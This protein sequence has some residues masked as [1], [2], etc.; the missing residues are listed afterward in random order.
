MHWSGEKNSSG[1][2][3]PGSPVSTGAPPALMGR[4]EADQT[5]AHAHG[6]YGLYG[7][8]GTGSTGFTG[9]I[10]VRALRALRA[11]WALLGASDRHLFGGAVAYL[12]SPIWRVCRLFGGMH[13]LFGRGCR[14]FGAVLARFA[15][16]LAELP[17]IWRLRKVCSCAGRTIICRRL[18][19]GKLQ[20]HAKSTENI[21]KTMVSNCFSDAWLGPLN[22]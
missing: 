11:L 7:L 2:L 14:L 22:V 18:F 21:Q 5:V 4:A 6:L 8:T 20:N 17:S 12:A 15:V 19:N 16:Y 9:I 3:D 13:R 10:L 1:G